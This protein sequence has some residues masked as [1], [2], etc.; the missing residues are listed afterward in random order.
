MAKK[1]IPRAEFHGIFVECRTAHKVESPYFCLKSRISSWKKLKFSW[2]S[3]WNSTLWQILNST[4]SKIIPWYSTIG[5][6]F[7]GTSN[8]TLYY[9]QVWIIRIQ[10]TEAD[11]RIHECAS[12]FILKFQT[13]FGLHTILI[14]MFFWEISKKIHIVSEKLW[15]ILR[16]NLSKSRAF[17]ISWF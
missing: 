6:R 15:I 10:N 7:L 16:N 5:I 8:A 12:S 9:Q 3:S 11:K 2:S 13:K 4:K 1:R 14:E 17:K